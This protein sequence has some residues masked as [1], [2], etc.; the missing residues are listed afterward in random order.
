MDKPHQISPEAIQEWLL[1]NLLNPR[2]LKKEQSDE[3]VRELTEESEEVLELLRRDFDREHV[4][5]EIL[6]L[7]LP[8]S[9]DIRLWRDVAIGENVH[10]PA[11]HQYGPVSARAEPNS[12]RAKSV[13]GGKPYGSVHGKGSEAPSKF[14]ERQAGFIRSK[15]EKISQL[16]K[17]LEAAKADH[18][19]VLAGLQEYAATALLTEVR[20]AAAP[21]F[22][23]GPAWTILRAI[24]GRTGKEVSG[25]DQERETKRVLTVLHALCGDA[26]FES[27]IKSAIL[28]VCHQFYGK[29]HRKWQEP[30]KAPEDYVEILTALDWPAQECLERGVAQSHVWGE[31]PEDIPM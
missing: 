27:A 8:R 7:L 5:D 18:E 1:R 12:A 22:A 25:A 15:A 6:S 20:N 31:P 11:N 19:D 16:E 9:I 2:D 3:R 29:V 13:S 14:M 28:A 30:W 17:E 23:M 21:V 24:Q 4:A 10:L 26:A